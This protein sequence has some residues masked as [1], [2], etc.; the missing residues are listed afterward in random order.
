MSL[1][2]ESRS[3]VKSEVLNEKVKTLAISRQLSS[4]RIRLYVSYANLSVEALKD[5]LKNGTM[6]QKDWVRQLRQDLVNHG[7]KTKEQQD[8]WLAKPSAKLNLVASDDFIVSAIGERSQTVPCCNVDCYR[9]FLC[10]K[11]TNRHAP[12]DHA[13]SHPSDGGPD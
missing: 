1:R 2:F 3:D 5:L 11:E 9:M 6:W 4:R 12:N 7:L 8:A 10:K 13:P